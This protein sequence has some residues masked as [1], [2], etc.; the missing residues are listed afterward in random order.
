MDPGRNHSLR[1]PFAGR[2]TPPQ[3]QIQAAVRA[4][5][6]RFSHGHKR[7]RPVAAKPSNRA[8]LFIAQLNSSKLDSLNLT[9]EEHLSPSAHKQSVQVNP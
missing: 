5:Q 7:L 9:L 8:A 3:K 2:V 4:L 1:A 6:K